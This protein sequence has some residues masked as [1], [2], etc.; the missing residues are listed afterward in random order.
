MSD[1]IMCMSELTDKRSPWD[2]CSHVFCG[3]VVVVP[4]DRGGPY[5][6]LNVA[7]VARGRGLWSVFRVRCSDCVVERE[8][9]LRICTWE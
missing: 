1:N 7:S 4:V 6:C 8:V 3:V 5:A 2:I 9:W